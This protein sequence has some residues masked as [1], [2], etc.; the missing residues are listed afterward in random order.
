MPQLPPVASHRRRQKIASTLINVS[1]AH[2]PGESERDGG[3]RMSASPL[4]WRHKFL[5][6]LPFR[7]LRSLFLCALRVRMT[8]TN[9]V[10]T[11][12]GPGRIK[13]PIFWET[14]GHFISFTTVAN[15][16][17]LD[18]MLYAEHSIIRIIF[19]R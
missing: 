4:P 12:D 7:R 9:F 16:N 17:S 18:E 19:M 13:Q 6:F 1:A 14:I 10:R 3:T 8:P 11:K 15:V 2:T 5:A